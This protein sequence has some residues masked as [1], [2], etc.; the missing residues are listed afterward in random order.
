MAIDYNDPQVIADAKRKLSEMYAKADR[1][2]RIAIGRGMGYDKARAKP[3]S[4]RRSAERLAKYKLGKSSKFD[5]TPYFNDIAYQ[6]PPTNR[7][8]IGMP[9]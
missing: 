8:L 9:P 6:D 4:A 5:V 2:G 7:R 1:R 3:D